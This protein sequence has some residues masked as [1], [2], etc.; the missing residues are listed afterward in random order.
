MALRN[1]ISYEPSDEWERFTGRDGD[2]DGT[3]REVS[4]WKWSIGKVVHLLT[5]ARHVAKMADGCHA[6]AAPRRAAPRS[7]V[8]PRALRCLKNARCV[9]TVSVHVINPSDNVIA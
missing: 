4:K 2:V 6:T 5:S 9:S 7:V 8:R 1:L 3:F